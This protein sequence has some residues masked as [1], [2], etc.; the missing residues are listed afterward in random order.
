MK[1]WPGDFWRLRRL[2]DPTS[3]LMGTPVFAGGIAAP[4]QTTFR[5]SDRVDRGRA[6]LGRV[7]FLSPGAEKTASVTWIVMSTAGNV[8]RHAAGL[9]HDQDDRERDRR[10]RVVWAVSHEQACPAVTCVVVSSLQPFEDPPTKDLALE[11]SATKSP[12]C[13]KSC[14]II[15]YDGTGRFSPKRLRVVPR[16]MVTDRITSGTPI[17][18]LSNWGGLPH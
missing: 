15:T 5:M 4:A 17:V 1:L 18:R 6:K 3:R 14:P 8:Q 11:L 7:S 2:A 12:D 13:S 9:G 16:L 10:Q